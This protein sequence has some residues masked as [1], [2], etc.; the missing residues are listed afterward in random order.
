MRTAL[1][2]W[3]VALVACAPPASH[4]E[5]HGDDHGDE[6]HS[7][8]GDEVHGSDESAQ[9]IELDPH[10]V[11]RNGIRTAPA[12]THLLL[13]ALEVPAEVQINHVRVAHV[14]PL[15]RGRLQTVDAHLGDAVTKGQV[16][17]QMQS[18]DL[19]SLRAALK[20]AQARKRVADAALERKQR[21]A[22]SGVT[23][24]KDVLAAEGDVE[25][26]AADV[27]A[28]RAELSVYG[29]GGRG[30]GASVSLRS[31]LAGVVLERHAIE[32]EV[33]DS[34]T[35]LFVVADL[36]RVWV[37]GSVFERDVS[38]VVKGLPTE[39]SVIAAPGRSWRGVVDY[40]DP[41]L[42]PE[43]RTVA[44]RVELD[45]LDGVLRPGLFGTIA[46]GEPE[47]EG[48]EVLAVPDAALQNIEGRMVVFAEVAPS[49]FEALT[50]IPGARAHGLTEIKDG[51]D[52]GTPIAVAGSFALKSKLLE[53]SLG[54]GHAH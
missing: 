51:L 10:V 33:V 21:L 52:V 19:G 39:V 34:A 1:S 14:A 26:A 43:S 9:R 25:K 36:G 3:L 42:D 41:A 2:I 16:L 47:A 32:G 23:A 49:V 4:E 20:Q 5:A 45:N 6:G 17:A 53:A 46:I 54:E 30:S 13:G 50:V 44:I 48:R 12:Q 15:V 11:E 35:T 40:V 31:P 27:Q 28:A 37:I 22:D 29:V 24:K 18:T 38:R 7:D 8:H